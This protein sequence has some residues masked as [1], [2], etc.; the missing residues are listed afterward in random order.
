MKTKIFTITLTLIFA[1]GIH[2]FPGDH[3]SLTCVENFFIN[4]EGGKVEKDDNLKS[5][6]L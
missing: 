5:Q 1:N 2:S 3:N 4:E 6:F